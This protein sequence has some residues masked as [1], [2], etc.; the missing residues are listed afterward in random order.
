MLASWFRND[1]MLCDWLFIVPSLFVDWFSGR[2][3][4]RL[5]HFQLVCIL[6]HETINCKACHLTVA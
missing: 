5:H 4:P 2:R 6:S 3:P 1:A